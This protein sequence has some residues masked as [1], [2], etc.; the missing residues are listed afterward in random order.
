MKVEDTLIIL[1]NVI[2]SLANLSPGRYILRHTIRNGAFAAVYKLAE[3]S[4]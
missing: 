1:H 2:Q 4:G 3:S